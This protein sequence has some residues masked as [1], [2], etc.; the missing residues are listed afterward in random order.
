MRWCG[1]PRGRVL[2]G[3]RDVAGVDAIALRRGIG[4][5]IQ[6][7]G[8]FPHMTIERNVGMPLELSGTTRA[9]IAARAAEMLEL[10]GLAGGV[11]GAVSVAVERRA[12]AAGR[13][14]RGRWLASRRCC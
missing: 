12:A 14:W 5:V 2:V 6:E 3:G 4:Y 7:T 9:E 10:V 8:L 11:C 13:G 1:R